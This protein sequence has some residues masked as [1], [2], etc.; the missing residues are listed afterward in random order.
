M[1]THGSF[2]WNELATTDP[3]AAAT[4]YGKVVGWEVQEFPMPDGGTYYIFRDGEQ[5]RGGLMALADMQGPG[6]G[7][8][9]PPCWM[10]YIGVDDVD[11]ACA[12]AT[13]AGGA[14]LMPPF[15]IPGVGRI[16]TIRDPQGAAVCLMKEAM[17]A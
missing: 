2:V 5:N 7:A 16:A 11:Q 15:D 14:I 1:S 3:K 13:E 17:E 6:Q 8:G 12:R 10:S 9:M 4:F